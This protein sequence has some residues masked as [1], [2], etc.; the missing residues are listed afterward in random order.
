MLGNPVAEVRQGNQ[1]SPEIGFHS[2][3]DRQYLV[4]DHQLFKR[5]V[6]FLLDRLLIRAPMQA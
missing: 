2:V 4:L 3:I 1:V 6:V 5:A